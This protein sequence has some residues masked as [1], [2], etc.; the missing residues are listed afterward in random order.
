MKYTE[1]NEAPPMVK[2]DTGDL[3]VCTPSCQHDVCHTPARYPRYI[4]HSKEGIY[5]TNVTATAVTNEEKDGLL[6]Y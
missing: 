5:R 2:I 6:G 1:V 4:H 3:L